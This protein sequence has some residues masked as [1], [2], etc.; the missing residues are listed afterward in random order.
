LGLEP[1]LVYTRLTRGPRIEA[2]W[3]PFSAALICP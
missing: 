2:N 3:L 1:A